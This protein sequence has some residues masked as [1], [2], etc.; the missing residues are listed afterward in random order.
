MHRTLH[1]V[2]P[3]KAGVGASLAQSAWSPAC[4]DPG[5]RRDDGGGEARNAQFRW[6]GMTSGVGV[7]RTL[8]TVTPAKGGGLRKRKMERI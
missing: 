5:L 1:T 2:T 7:H 3:A 8:H 6:P 4:A